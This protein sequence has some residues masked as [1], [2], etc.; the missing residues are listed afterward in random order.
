MMVDLS[1][2]PRRA[3]PYKEIIAAAVESFVPF[4]ERRSFDHTRSAKDQLCERIEELGVIANQPVALAFVREELTE[5]EC[6]TI[7]GSK[8]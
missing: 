5:S 4:P 7:C 6:L 3:L 1:T 8:F 2:W